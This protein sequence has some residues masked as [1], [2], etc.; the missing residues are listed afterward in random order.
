MRK[1]RG[2]RDIVYGVGINDYDG[3]ISEH[4]IPIKSYKCWV[5][6][7]ERCYDK[8]I[9]I[10]RPSYNDVTICE[11]WL[12]FS[13]FKSWFDTNYIEGCD[14]DK[15]ILVQGNK[16]YSPEFCCFVP[17]RINT[18]LL[19]KQRTNTNGFIGI[20][21]DENGRYSASVNM[22]GIRKHIGYYSTPEEASAAYVKAKSEYTTK[23]VNEYYNN[24]MISE[25]VR[26]AIINRDWSR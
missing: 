4:Q 21:K 3:Y 26:D 18:L 8:K 12:K 13:N 9:K 23:V 6:V 15:D 2:K 22:A 20:H 25:K 11:D 16:I 1:G 7:L 10:K 5:R 19:N 17:R 14:I 24:G